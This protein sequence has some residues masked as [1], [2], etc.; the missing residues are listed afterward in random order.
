MD[1]K[2]LKSIRDAYLDIIQEKK[3]TPAQ[4]KELDVDNDMDIDADDFKKLRKKKGKEEVE[5]KKKQSAEDE[6]L[7]DEEDTTTED[8]EEEMDDENPKKSTKKKVEGKGYKKE[9]TT[10]EDEIRSKSVGMR[11]ALEQVWLE[12][13]ERKK[14]VK[15]AT[16]PEGL[17]DKESPKSKEFIDKHE[18]EEDDTL[19]KSLDDVS[20]AGRATKQSPSRG[21]DQLNV[22]DKNPVK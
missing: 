3:L 10:F 6:E 12:A 4:Q 19:V 22:G 13:T 1:I 5:E 20:K 16:D 15:G 11:R 21:N 18:T 17:L 14:H 8:D 9:E 7:G 2:T